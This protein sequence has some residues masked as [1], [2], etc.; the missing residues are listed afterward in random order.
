MFDFQEKRKLKQF[1]YSKVTLIILAI[2][3]L[4]LLNSV[5]NVFLKERETN[6]T[7]KKLEREFLELKE[8]ETLLREEIERLS[9]PRGVEEE[10]RSKFEVSKEGED[11]MVIIDP[12]RKDNANTDDSKK[13]FWS[14]L[15]NV[16]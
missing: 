11:V 3:V 2:V 9:A 15:L 5:W 8:R 1:L 6:E 10:I 13:G 12:R 14:R 4:L 7:R 16:F